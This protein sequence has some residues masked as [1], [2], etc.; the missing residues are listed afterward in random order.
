MNELCECIIGYEGGVCHLAHVLKIPTII[1]PWHS[2]SCDH[3]KQSLRSLKELHSI[4]HTLHLDRKTYF[5]E[6]PNELLSWLPGELRY[7]ISQLH[8][9]QGNNMFFA[10]GF[11][12]DNSFDTP[13]LTEMETHFIQ[14][15]I[16]NPVIGGAQ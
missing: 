2:W 1:L 3:D 15:Y 16:G 6:S 12:L 11:V 9:N 8:N 10:D 13:P 14:T 4:P 5:L 7:K